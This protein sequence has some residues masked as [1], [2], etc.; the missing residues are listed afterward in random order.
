MKF[1]ATKKAD[2]NRE[3]DGPAAE[4]RLRKWASKDGSGDKETIDWAKYARGFLFV[5]SEDKENFGAYYFPHHDVIDGELYVVWRGVATAMAY[6]LKDY[7][8]KP[9]WADYKQ[10]MYNHLVKHYEQF[11]KEPPELKSV[12]EI[13]FELATGKLVAL[14]KLKDID[15]VVMA[16]ASCEIV[17]AEKIA[18]QRQTKTVYSLSDT[19]EK[20]GAVLNRANKERLMKARDLIQEVLD[21]A[22][23][24]TE[25]EHSNE[26]AIKEAAFLYALQTLKEELKKIF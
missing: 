7:D 16:Y 21:S 8:S 19:V 24:S 22:E 2:E 17:K 4:Q 20:V 23:P 26:T 5:D 9:V 11:D 18:M 10:E 6:L 25:I 3:W 1:E 14:R 13:L 12:Q 15:D